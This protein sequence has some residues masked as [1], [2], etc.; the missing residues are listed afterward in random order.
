MATAHLFDSAGPQASRA[1][2]PGEPPRFQLAD[3][4]TLMRRRAR[5]IFGV[6]TTCV[7]LTALVL[8]LLPTLYSASAV[9]MLDQRKNNVADASSVLSELPTD[10]ASVQNQIQILTSRDLALRVV[11]KLGLENDPEFNSGLLLS[12]QDSES[13]RARV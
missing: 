6:A 8:L 12:A 1:A 3:L 7:V 13:L 9:V 10:A 2:R 4:L 5:L 11:D